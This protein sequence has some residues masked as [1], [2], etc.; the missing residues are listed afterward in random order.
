MSVERLPPFTL[1]MVGA[2]GAGKTS[3]VAALALASRGHLGETTAPWG[4]SVFLH[5]QRRPEW[6]PPRTSFTTW[7]ALRTS[8]RRYL[9]LDTPGRADGFIQAAGALACCDGAL[10]VVDAGKVKTSTLT[11]YCAAARME[12]PAR[13]VA[14]THC[15]GVDA[16]ALDRAEQAAR[17]ELAS[18]GGDPD[19]VAVHRVRSRA[20]LRGDAVALAGV[21][22]LLDV[23]ESW[24]DP[25]RDLD[26]EL[27]VTVLES[28]VGPK[29]LNLAGVL[30][31]G[32]VRAGDGVWIATSANAER[33]TVTE[34]KRDGEAV[35]LASAG[36]AAM[37]TLTGPSVVLRATRARALTGARPRRPRELVATVRGVNGRRGQRV[38]EPGAVFFA[39]VGATEGRVTLREGEV[40][41]GEETR[42]RLAPWAEAWWE[43]GTPVV[44]RGPR[45]TGLASSASGVVAV[46]EA[47]VAEG[48]YA[49][50]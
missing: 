40:R 42:V 11:G 39:V 45:R 10:L 25:A 22:A 26:G 29:E 7:T 33:L 30:R 16:G 34:V 21:R 41:A 35:A 3:L 48:L 49:G 46:G 13:A 31:R 27:R 8:R 9:A 23:V 14:L 19:E 6:P 50:P 1:A 24:H 20:A 47:A 44:L 43:A 17:G 37:V 38:F 36:E 18:A 28:F 15:E 12:R 2:E 5:G 32:A 4:P